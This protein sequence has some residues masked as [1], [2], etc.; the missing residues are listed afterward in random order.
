M[1][2]LKSCIGRDGL[3][4]CCVAGW[5][6]QLHLLEKATEETLKIKLFS[7]AIM[8]KHTQITSISTNPSRVSDESVQGVRMH[9]S[10]TRV[11]FWTPIHV[12]ITT[13]YCE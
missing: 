11:T 4:G 6:V 3:K 12:L 7:F 9:F 5:G 8:D 13:Y 2:G 10:Q 1:G